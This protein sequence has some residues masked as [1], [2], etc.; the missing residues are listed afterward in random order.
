MATALLT[1]I[2]VLFI[3]V[4]NYMPINRMNVIFIMHKLVKKSSPI[5]YMLQV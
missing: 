1:L 5:N 4:F 3:T 2:S